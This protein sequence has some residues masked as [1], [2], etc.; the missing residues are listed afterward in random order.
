MGEMQTTWHQARQSCAIN[1]ACRKCHHDMVG[2]TITKVMRELT[3][4][5]IVGTQR[6][7]G[8]CSSPTECMNRGQ[9]RGRGMVTTTDEPFSRSI[10]EIVAWMFR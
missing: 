7:H 6:S 3:R 4:A 8:K 10:F 2:L 9:C 1:P 5:K